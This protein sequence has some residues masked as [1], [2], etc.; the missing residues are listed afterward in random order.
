MT[1]GERINNFWNQFLSKKTISPQVNDNVPV[2]EILKLANFKKLEKIIDHKIV[3][4]IIFFQALTHRSFLTLYPNTILKS[5]ERLEFLGDSILNM[6]VGEFLFEIYPNADEGSLTKIRSRLVNRKALATYGQ[7]LNLW[8][9]ILLSPSVAQSLEKG[10]DTVLADCFEAIVG[11]L[12]LDA[13][14]VTIKKFIRKIILSS[15]QL[16]IASTIDQN[17]KSLLLE[18]SQAVGNGI[19]RYTI[20]KAEG[21]DHDRLFTIEVRVNNE[22][23]GIGTGKNKKEAEQSAAEEAIKKIE[24]LNLNTKA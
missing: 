9:L 16:K 7:E 20:I 17:Y 14:I 21:P 4:K 12:Y 5:N 8:E 13:G 24:N 1:L 2:E 19:P 15:A 10:S 6:V 22:L 3:D 11:A 18:Y 23:Y